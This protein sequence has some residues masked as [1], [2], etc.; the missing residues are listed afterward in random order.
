[1]KAR[2]MGM[3]AEQGAGVPVVGAGYTDLTPARELPRRGAARRII[4]RAVAG[5]A[6]PWHDGRER[7]KRMNRRQIPTRGSRTRG[8][9][10]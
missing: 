9:R 8:A 10:P 4:Y 3:E 7:G 2:A 5:P 1:M 6:P